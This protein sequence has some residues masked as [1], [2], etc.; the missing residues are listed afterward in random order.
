M[1]KTSLY[2]VVIGCVGLVF[3]DLEV[4]ALDS[5]GELARMF[6]GVMG[7]EWGVLYT[8]RSALTN[9]VIFAFCGLSFAVVFGGLL[10]FFFAY[11]PVRIF[12]AMIRAVHEIFWALLFLPAV[13]LNPLC[14]VL[15]IGVPYAG[16][17]AKVYAEILQEAERRPLQGLPSGAGKIAH[18]FYGVWPTIARDVRHYTAYR[19]E[20]A[21]RS[22]AVLGFIGLPTLG[23]HLETAFREGLYGEAA[24]LLYFFYAL[25]ASLNY[26]LKARLAP[27]YAIASWFLLAGEWS[28]S[29]ANIWRF[30][31]YDILPWPMRR[32]GFADGSLAVEF[33]LGEV[34][35]WL[36]NLLMGEALTGLWNT[37]V[38]TQVALLATA[39]FALVGLA[40]VC[41]HFV[42]RWLRYLSGWALIV[43]RTTP[44]YALA[45]FLVQLWGP[46]MLPAA[47][48]IVLHNGAIMSH[49]MGGHA[50][51]LVLRLDAPVGRVDRY[52]Y[53]V[54]PRVYGQL[55]AFLL[56]RWEVM[57]R[58]SA[59]L[60]ILGIYTLGFYIDSAFAEDKMDQAALLILLTALLNVCVDAISQRVRR[61]FKLA[62]QAEALLNPQR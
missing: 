10:A 29:W 59:I 21:L 22:S 3:A 30:F 19:F 49:L 9:T 27:F 46:S 16:I 38:L 41:R 42:A 62:L 51:G 24:A 58:E 60:G 55:L 32:A 18:F 23:F 44:E 17:L 5:W 4:A 12:C 35:I 48:A 36:A 33:P 13:G 40:G 20:C 47:V 43:L 11:T 26:W 39:L 15:A 34:W 52:F 2:F 37:L 6:G 25:V 54:L 8:L 56:Y 45:Y 50:D 28:F 31:S 1:L 7:P 57:L 53:E 61:S 14:G